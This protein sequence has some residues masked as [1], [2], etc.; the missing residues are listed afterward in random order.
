VATRRQF[1]DVTAGV[2]GS[3]VG[4][5]NEIDGYWAIGMLCRELAERGETGVA[6]DLI[7]PNGDATAIRWSERLAAEVKRRKMD[8]SWLT[9]ASLHLT[10]SEHGWIDTT[11][12]KRSWWRRR[13]AA[14]R[15]P[16]YDFRAELQLEDDQG[17]R[18]DGARTGWC[19][20]HDPLIEAHTWDGRRRR[21]VRHEN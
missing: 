14:E 21:M 6:L 17:T 1:K 18:Y 13:P 8:R 11:P 3:F 5:N 4:R 20:P 9:G 15:L 7:E 12:R 10:F 2:L 19:W 16:V